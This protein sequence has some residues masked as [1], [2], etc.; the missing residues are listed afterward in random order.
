MVP[1]IGCMPWFETLCQDK[2]PDNLFI[3]YAQISEQILLTVGHIQ[4]TTGMKWI[5]VK[6]KGVDNAP[7]SVQHCARGLLLLCACRCESSPVSPLIY[8]LR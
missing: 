1:L 3:A 5:H 4:F 2:T 6:Q 7:S 8:A